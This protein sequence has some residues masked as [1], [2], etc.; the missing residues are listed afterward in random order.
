MEFKRDRQRLV[1]SGTSRLCGLETG[2]WDRNR[3]RNSWVAPFVVQSFI[4]PRD[5]ESRETHGGA[6]WESNG[7]WAM[8]NVTSLDPALFGTTATRALARDRYHLRVSVLC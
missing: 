3:D 4:P 6:L 2:R 8:A 5:P 1:D 7:S